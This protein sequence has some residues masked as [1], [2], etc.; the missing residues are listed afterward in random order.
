MGKP[1]I[2]KGL[3]SVLAL[4]IFI[5]TV[6]SCKCNNNENGPGGADTTSIAPPVEEMNNSTVVDTVSTD[7]NTEG[8]DNSSAGRNSQGSSGSTG[9]NSGTASS[10]TT[11]KDS[12]TGFEKTGQYNSQKNVPEPLNLDDKKYKNHPPAHTYGDT[13]PH[14]DGLNSTR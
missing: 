9:S 3:K 8:T 12:R 10:H 11:A 14:N 1:R 7:V 4:C 2:M 6:N 13:A 5:V